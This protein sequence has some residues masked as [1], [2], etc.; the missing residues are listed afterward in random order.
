MIEAKR[1]PWVAR[2][3]EDGSRIDVWHLEVPG[4]AVAT[5]GVYD[6]ET[7]QVTITSEA[8]VSAQLGEWVVSFGRRVRTPGSGDAHKVSATPTP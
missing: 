1:G 4:H 5:I 8:E 3:H 6:H 7:G 2:C